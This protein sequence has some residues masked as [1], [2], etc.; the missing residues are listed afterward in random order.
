MPLAERFAVHK[1][2]VSQLRTGRG[3]KSDLDVLQ[4]AVL[5]AALAEFQPGAV[6]SAVADVPVKARKHLRRAIPMVVCH[7]DPAH[8]RAIEELTGVV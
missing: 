3:A 6:E 1:L 4:A 2:I 5:C 7:L 8:P